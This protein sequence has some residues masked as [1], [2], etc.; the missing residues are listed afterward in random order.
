VRRVGVFVAAAVCVGVG[1]IALLLAHDIRRWRHAVAVGDVR[2]R[3]AASRTDLWQPST[4]V[5]FGAA[6]ALLGLDDDLAYR[7]AVRRFRLGRPRE[8]GLTQ[9]SLL[10][11]RAQAQQELIGVVQADHNGKR[12]SQAANFVGALAFAGAAVDQ[13]RRIQYL[14]AGM[15]ALQRAV[16]LDPT[17]EDAKYNLELLLSRLHAAQLEQA[18]QRREPG[19]SNT[20]KG[21]GAN[22]SGSGY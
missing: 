11:I 4:I 12:A 17:D 2:Y 9:P 22:R 16:E 10:A 13:Q 3:L 1:V 18:E 19:R 6:R 15:A 20:G 21:A 14:K 5:P 7:T 8:F